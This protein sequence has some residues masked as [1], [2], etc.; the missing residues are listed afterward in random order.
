MVKDT[1]QAIQEAEERAERILLEASEEAKQL[2]SDARREAAALHEEAVVQLK[3]EAAEL[4]QQLFTE[5][6]A[7]LSES[8]R[9][10]DEE[11]LLLKQSAEVRA[12]EAAAQIAKRLI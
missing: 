10:V 6:E 3:K 8:A 9:A 2:V 4:E 5:G 11:V 7:F 1:I 12:E